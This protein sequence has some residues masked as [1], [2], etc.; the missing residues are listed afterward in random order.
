MVFN[1]SKRKNIKIPKNFENMA[2]RNKVTVSRDKNGK[3]QVS[4]LSFN[5]IL[6]KTCNAS[7]VYSNIWV[8]YLAMCK[9]LYR[10]NYHTT[11]LSKLQFSKNG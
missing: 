2:Y 5:S 10:V 11:S 4:S 8:G 7:K 3:K 9:N 1:T 6:K